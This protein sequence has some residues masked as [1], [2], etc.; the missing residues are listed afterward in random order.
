M[1]DLT[2]FST[3]SVYHVRLDIT[4]LDDYFPA[5]LGLLTGRLTRHD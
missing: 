1:L 3:Y 5:N 4:Y 2:H